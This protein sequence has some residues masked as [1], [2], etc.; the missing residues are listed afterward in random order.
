MVTSANKKFHKIPATPTTATVA[1][2]AMAKF[3]AF[4]ELDDMVF[5]LTFPRRPLKNDLAIYRR[6]L[7]IFHF[8]RNWFSAHS[9]QMYSVKYNVINDGIS[10][11]IDS[12]R[13][14]LVVW[15]PQVDLLRNSMLVRLNFLAASGTRVMNFICRLLKILK[16]SMEKQPALRKIYDYILPR[17]VMFSYYMYFI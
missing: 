10:Q 17:Y 4:V 1:T 15:T 16:E 5:Y 9:F 14:E 11:I 8:L 13:R 2:A 12:I 3:L 6:G 7:T